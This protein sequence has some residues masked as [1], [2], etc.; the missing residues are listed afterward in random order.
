MADMKTCGW[1]GQNTVFYSFGIATVEAR[2]NVR[3]HLDPQGVMFNDALDGSYV[4][5]LMTKRPDF[6]LDYAP[7]V[8]LYTDRYAEAMA[9]LS[10]GDVF[11]VVSN[12]NGE[13]GGVGAFQTPI[14]RNARNVWRSVELPTLQRNEAINRIISVA[15]DQNWAHSVDWNKGDGNLLPESTASSQQVPAVPQAQGPAATQTCY[16]VSGASACP[17]SCPTTFTTSTSVKPTITAKPACDL[18]NQDP[19]QGITQ[20]YCLCDSSVTLT[21]L[22]IPTNGHPSDSCAY[23]TIPKTGE[24]SITTVKQT[25]TSNCHVCTE[26]E[27]NPPTCTSTVPGCTPT[28]ATSATPT[29]TFVV[30]LSNNTVHAGNANDANNGADFRNNI[31]STLKSACP[32]TKSGQAGQCDTT[33][34]YQ[35][36]DI[37]TVVEGGDM[38]GTLSFQFEDSRYLSTGERDRMLAVAVG[39]FQQAVGK[40]CSKVK[41]SYPLDPTESGCHPPEKRHLVPRIPIGPGDTTYGQTPDAC[42][43]DMNICN[44]PDH[45]SMLSPE[46]RLGNSLTSFTGVELAGSEGPYTNHM[47]IH[48][49]FEIG[50]GKD[51]AFN[52]FICEMII[53][54]LAAL[55]N[56]VAPEL[57]VGDWVSAEELQEILC[58]Q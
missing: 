6:R 37:W 54:G 5:F 46:C 35:I 17:T 9:R 14:D 22:S 33:K 29:S 41:Y 44:G 26:I 38:D 12:H 48:V 42:H 39:S 32:E 30:N 51:S 16:S 7:R 23:T 25:Y 57:A 24:I 58:A 15:K 34:K 4:D 31:M 2:T 43:S 21:P 19:D 1:V 47:N 50:N 8:L 36:H 49:S 11:L 13:G 52:E 20:A 3:D 45:I 28:T 56:V 53:D 27:F 40:S 10:T 18:H 55:V